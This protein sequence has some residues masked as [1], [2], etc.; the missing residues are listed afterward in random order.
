MSEV[1]IG[2]STISVRSFATEK[3]MQ[4]AAMIVQRKRR[5]GPSETMALRAMATPAHAIIPEKTMEG[6][7]FNA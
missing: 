2:A 5:P 3:P 1:M 6:S 7:V 4:E